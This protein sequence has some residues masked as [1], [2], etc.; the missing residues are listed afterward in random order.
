M[1]GTNTILLN[2]KELELHEATI[3]LADGS[4]CVSASLGGG[5]H[6]LLWWGGKKKGGHVCTGWVGPGA[7]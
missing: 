5:G 6:S 1:E 4:R 3:Q 2:Y 7:A